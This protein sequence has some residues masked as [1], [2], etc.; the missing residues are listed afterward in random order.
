MDIRR[1]WT[2]DEQQLREWFDHRGTEWA[3][4]LTKADKL[5]RS[6]ANNRIK[7]FEKLLPHVAVFGISSLKKTGLE[8]VQKLLFKEWGR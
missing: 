6:Q 2:E 4:V 5:S 1:E 3:L 7:E 8:E